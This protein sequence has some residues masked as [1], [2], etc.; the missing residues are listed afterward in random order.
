MDIKTK[1]SFKRK[2]KYNDLKTYNFYF[3]LQKMTRI[4]SNQ[5]KRKKKKKVK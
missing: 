4:I 5:K 2:K 3:I 1:L